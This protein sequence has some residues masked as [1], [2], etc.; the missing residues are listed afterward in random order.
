MK[1]ADI[2]VLYSVLNV[3]YIFKANGGLAMLMDDQIGKIRRIFQI[4]RERHLPAQLLSFHHAQ[5]LHDIAFGHCFADLL[6]RYA[7]RNQRIRI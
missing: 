4:G 7:L 6:Q 2:T 1:T 3:G 5:S